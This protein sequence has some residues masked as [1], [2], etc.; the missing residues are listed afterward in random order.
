MGEATDGLELGVA[1]ADPI[2]LRIREV[3]MALPEVEGVH[4]EFRE[5]FKRYRLVLWLRDGASHLWNRD[6]TAG[7]VIPY[8]PAGVGLELRLAG[9][10]D[11]PEDKDAPAPGVSY[12]ERVE[13][14]GPPLDVTHLPKVMGP[15]SR[16]RLVKTFE[17]FCDDYRLPEEEERALRKAALGLIDGNY[18]V[19]CAPK[20]LAPRKKAPVAN[21]NA[22]DL[23]HLLERVGVD[24][25]RL[26]SAVRE[27]LGV[28]GVVAMKV[29]RSLHVGPCLE[30]TVVLAAGEHDEKAVLEKVRRAAR[31]VVPGHIRI[32]AVEAIDSPARAG[33]V[34]TRF[35]EDVFGVLPDFPAK[36]QVPVLPEPPLAKRVRA[37]ARAL[38]DVID[39]SIAFRQ[40]EN[41]V[42]VGVWAMNG[43]PF[44]R[45]AEA[46]RLA[47]A[48]YIP[49]AMALTVRCGLAEAAGSA[50][51]QESLVTEREWAADP[52]R[53]VA[54]IAE[55]GSLVDDLGRLQHL[56]RVERISVLPDRVL[57]EV[58]V[59]DDRDADLTLRRVYD[60]VR[61]HTD[62]YLEVEAVLWK[63]QAP[64]AHA[65][66]QTPEWAAPDFTPLRHALEALPGFAMLSVFQLRRQDPVSIRLR[67]RHDAP[68]DAEMRRAV[69]TQAGR[70]LPRLDGIPLFHLELTRESAPTWD[71]LP[72]GTTLDLDA[73]RAAVL[74]LPFVS[75]AEV[76]YSPADNTVRVRYAYGPDEPGC[77]T[78]VDKRKLIWRAAQQA[79][80]PSVF[81]RVPLDPDLLPAPKPARQLVTG[82]GT[83]S[84]G[85]SRPD[86]TVAELEAIHEAVL[87]VSFVADAE[88]VWAPQTRN[89]RVCYRFRVWHTDA[90]E[91]RTRIWNAASPLVPGHARLQVAVE[92]DLPPA[93]PRPYPDP[94]AVAEAVRALP[95][96]TDVAVT[97]ARTP[98]GP[99][100]R[101]I[102]R[103]RRANPLYDGVIVAAQVRA[104]ATDHVSP[105]CQVILKENLRPSPDKRA[106]KEPTETR[107]RWAGRGREVVPVVPCPHC[108]ARSPWSPLLRSFTCPR[109]RAFVQACGVARCGLPLELAY[110]AGNLVCPAHG[111]QA[112]CDPAD[113]R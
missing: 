80:P 42:V 75:A 16:P 74:A 89:V 67:L 94:R 30:I 110:P 22:K 59:Y 5:K 34:T 99:G 105:D 82:A 78:A 40:S 49:A 47:V 13:C 28:A 21:S 96:V 33:G 61:R 113:L 58:E 85:D 45:L 23:V 29:L 1:R 25:H 36:E 24:A 31:P 111:I 17:E 108:G 6:R 3:V 69:A 101:A 104:A 38:P 98:V 91:L 19:L 51:A 90:Q 83:W 103:Y 76:S 107:P 100:F 95:S 84:L 46:V 93:E 71:A 68:N 53:E 9:N 2:A 35:Q 70:H 72:S 97:V 44:A 37:A 92:A 87:G 7:T 12:E 32:S 48:P 57:A 63:G 52:Y 20:A 10:A 56:C 18:E 4:V 109:H 41:R 55:P 112:H 86:V 27:V 102:I 11:F 79:L 54:L 106:G 81:L 60:A 73:V 65:P 14:A 26:F 66:A 8:L 39:V 64:Y 77:P 15:I 62:P 88:V 50:Q 43:A